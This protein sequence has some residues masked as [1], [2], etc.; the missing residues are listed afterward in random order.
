MRDSQPKKAREGC[1]I[2]L[3]SNIIITA[4]EIFDKPVGTA[5]CNFLS[6]RCLQTG[7]QFSLLAEDS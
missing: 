3:I 2:N 5:F 7:K 6:D 4:C 1:D